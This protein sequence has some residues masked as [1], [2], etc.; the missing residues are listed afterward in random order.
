[1]ARRYMRNL[2]GS[3]STRRVNRSAQSLSEKPV[4]GQGFSLAG[5]TGRPVFREMILQKSPA[6]PKE[7]AMRKPSFSALI[8][9]IEELGCVSW[10]SPM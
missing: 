1:M 10:L 4:L 2:L 6:G 3:E 7:K 8:A 9:R 5:L